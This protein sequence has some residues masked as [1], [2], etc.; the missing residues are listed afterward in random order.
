MFA[1]LFL[2]AA[3][4]SYLDRQPDDMLTSENIF[5]K[6]N[7][8]QRYLWNV[9]SYVPDEGSFRGIDWSNFHH[10]V[11]DLMSM[12]HSGFDYKKYMH[13]NMSPNSG[14]FLSLW[15][16]MYQGIREAT[17]FMEHVGDCPELT[18]AEVTQWKAEARYLRAYYYYE[19]LRFFGPV[20][21]LK[22]E[23][24][25]FTRDDLDEYS[26]TPWDE[27]VKWVCNEFDEAAKDLPTVANG[28]NYGRAT[29]GAALGIKTRL[30][31]Y[32]ARD[33]F[34]GQG[35]TGMYDNIKNRHGENLFSTT[36]D[37][38]KWKEV[39]DA[40]EAVMKLG[41]YS[42][43]ND[44]AKTPLEN[45]HNLYV[46]LDYSTENLVVQQVS[47]AYH[48]RVQC[49]PERT[50][51]S[52]TAY[53]TLAPTQKLVDAFAMA[54]GIY[55]VTNIDEPGYNHGLN[56]VFDTRSEL[57]EANEFAASG[58]TGAHPFFEM[59]T[60]ESYK[61][62][63]L[64]K[65]IQN[66]FNNREARF[67]LNVFWSG[68][69]WVSGAGSQLSCIKDNNNNAIPASIG[70][71]TGAPSGPTPTQNNYPPT[72]YMM[73]KWVDPSLANNQ[74]Y[75]KLSFPLL[76]YADI[77]LMYVEAKIEL[78]EI[79]SSCLS[80]WNEVRHRAFGVTDGSID[81][82]TIYP[83]VKDDQAT[84]RKYLRQ[85][86]LV[87]FCAEGIRFFDVRTWMTA[88]EDMTG[89]VVGCNITATD[90]KIGGDFWQRSSIFAPGSYGE[91]NVNDTKRNF[92]KKQYLYPIPQNELEKVPGMKQNLGW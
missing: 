15:Q 70:F 68:M 48:I 45:L 6:K 55:P 8:T 20:V 2:S 36:K 64:T 53:G 41:T 74:W 12:S 3:C 42:L 5:E 11:T 69:Q 78:N 86:R 28:A 25:D 24:A 73:L 14:A 29:K 76:R 31:L 4:D 10:N 19:L 40:A 54:N 16:K 26:R 18:S 50:G 35:G 34:N 39:A 47:N 46:S 85:E 52:G 71:Y 27:C 38:T 61:A 30:L 88:E 22:D 51:Y 92:T 49:M 1:V 87:E 32:N 67:Y 82:E 77:L 81:I 66:A 57:N 59:A 43:I 33:L 80:A 62:S 9:Y 13:N 83:D 75:N 56:P 84:A 63:L 72:G 58:K 91:G 37:L 89:E 65:P 44:P 60:D 21:L 90:D 7:T 79:D 17:Y 23:L